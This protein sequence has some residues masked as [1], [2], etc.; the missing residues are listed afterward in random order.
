MRRARLAIQRVGP[1]AREAQDREGQ[2]GHGVDQY[3]ILG[4]GLDTFA[5]RKPQL[6]SRFRIFEV[7]QPAPREW[8][9]RRLEDL[10][11]GVPAFLHLVP[12]DFEAGDTW[13]DRLPDA[14]FDRSRP[15]VVASTG[16]TTYLTRDTIAATS[17]PAPM[18][19]GL[20]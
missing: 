17:R 11:F 1:H 9:R 16:V 15:A 12:V 10:G 2:A 8:K 6:A 18:V 19:S 3:V 13:W 7:D 14:G 5:Q 4:A 20:R